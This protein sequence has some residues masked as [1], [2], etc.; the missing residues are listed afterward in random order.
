MKKGTGWQ[1]ERRQLLPNEAFTTPDK[2]VAAFKVQDPTLYEI[3]AISY[4]WLSKGH[5]D[6]HSFYRKQWL[7]LYQEYRELLAA[8]GLSKVRFVFWDFLSLF[9]EPRMAEEAK[10]FKD[11]LAVM[12]HMYACESI[13]VARLTTVSTGVTPYEDRG[14]PMLESRVAFSKS[15]SVVS[16]KGSG[17]VV[18]T[19]L[20]TD[21]NVCEI[22]KHMYVPPLIHP[23]DFNKQIDSKVFAAKSADVAHVKQLYK[24][25]WSEGG[26]ERTESLQYGCGF[27]DDDIHQ[28][29][30]LVTQ[31]P[32]LKL[33]D[34]RVTVGIH[35]FTKPAVTRL[36]G[37][38]KTRTPSIELRHDRTW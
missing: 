4:A 15:Q 36:E 28:L 6:P 24:D 27:T 38:C 11:A 10:L 2:A 26:L 33:I 17:H 7:Q 34:L 20:E 3:L 14:W 32:R 12:H 19:I 18:F 23:D 29:V 30:Q 37:V 21:P 16:H 25:L 9:Q 31:L 1:L 22:H 13:A 8:S 5:P 35:F